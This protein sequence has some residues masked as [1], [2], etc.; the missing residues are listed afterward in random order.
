ML[1]SK[2]TENAEL[3]VT[4]QFLLASAVDVVDESAKG[5]GERLLRLNLSRQRIWTY[6]RARS[7][8]G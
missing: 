3:N 7:L 5:C 6:L 1:I 8:F 4:R 2:P